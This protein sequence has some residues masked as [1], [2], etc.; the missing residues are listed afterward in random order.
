[1]W[2]KLTDMELSDEDKFDLAIPCIGG[3][4]QPDYPYG[5]KIALT[6]R[7]LEKLG[8]EADCSVGDLIDMRC[9][10]TVTSVS[11]E[12]RGGKTTARVELQ[13]EKIA[14]EDEAT[15]MPSEDP[16]DE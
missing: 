16:D 12:Q 13:I 5:L 2:T 15:E 6:E 7:E 8:L 9:F 4:Q 10:A 3:P 11:T 1:M 14:L